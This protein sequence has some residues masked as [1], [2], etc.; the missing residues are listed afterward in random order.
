MK[1]SVDI[2]DASYNHIGTED[3]NIAHEKG[4]WHH[5]F[6]CWIVHPD[7]KILVQQRGKNVRVNPDRLDVS[8]AGHLHAGEKMEDAVREIEEE[9]GI[10]TSYE[11]LTPL[12]YYKDAYD[13]DTPAG[14]LRI[15]HFTHAF[16][17]KDDTPLNQYHLQK[18]EVD[19]IYEVDIK[20]AVPFF[21]GDEDTITIEGYKRT[22]Q[23]LE[24]HTRT[25]TFDDFTA[26]RTRHFWLK[27][28]IMAER[29]LNGKKYLA[30]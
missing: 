27:V 30:I 12:G 21:H 24:P 11:A 20:D 14:P 17:M 29:Y 16:F 10:K 1:E 23:S 8:A 4:L 3:R 26:V 2:F 22:D 18:E 13:F 25:V 9:L 28:F 6:H 15:R 5:T 7:G 19:G